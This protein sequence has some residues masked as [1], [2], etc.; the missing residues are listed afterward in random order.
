M[1]THQQSAYLDKFQSDC[2]LTL[3]YLRGLTHNRPRFRLIR[4]KLPYHTC[5]FLGCFL[6]TVV[7]RKGS[8]AVYI[9]DADDW[10]WELICADTQTALREF[11]LRFG[12]HIRKEILFDPAFETQLRHQG[13][14]RI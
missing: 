14:Q 1:G 11:D 13:W 7:P 6:V 2:D 10:G 8:A 5:D 3:K 12:D 9:Q 4:N